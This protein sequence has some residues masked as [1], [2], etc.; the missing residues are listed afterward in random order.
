[1]ECDSNIK[2][3]LKYWSCFECVWLPN[4]GSHRSSWT[5]NSNLLNS[6]QDKKYW[7]RQPPVSPGSINS[8]DR[9]TNGA[10]LLPGC[11]FGHILNYGVSL[12]SPTCQTAK[13]TC[14]GSY[15][16]P[17]AYEGMKVQ[18][19]HHTTVKPIIHNPLLAT[20]VIE[21][22]RCVERCFHSQQ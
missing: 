14:H 5:G 4:T 3:Y 8:R 12:N 2:S 6:P 18:W 15:Q 11:K 22:Y 1:M 7:V 10:H 17:L 16:S 19:T 13:I 9:H 20:T 21:W